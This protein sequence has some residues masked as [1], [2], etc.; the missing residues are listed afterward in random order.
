MT[1]D[2]SNS[3]DLPLGAKISKKCR[4]QSLSQPR[5]SLRQCPHCPYSTKDSRNMQRYIGTHTGEKPYSCEVCGQCF[6]RAANRNI[7]LYRIHFA[8]RAAT[9]KTKVSK[10]KWINRRILKHVGV[11][12]YSCKTCER[13][14]AYCGSR[15]NHMRKVHSATDEEIA[16][17]DTNKKLHQCPHCPYSTKRYSNFKDH[18]RTH[19]GEKPYSCKECGRSYSGSTALSYHMYSQHMQKPSSVQP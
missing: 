4:K 13:C 9:G 17:L 16:Q 1:T 3:E 5:N 2:C 11:K 18:I 12:P 14:F 15:N 7:H 8:T 10:N 19:T 6:A